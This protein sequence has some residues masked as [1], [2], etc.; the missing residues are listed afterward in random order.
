MLQARAD[1]VRHSRFIADSSAPGPP[2]ALDT[3]S[4]LTMR[5]TLAASALIALMTVAACSSAPPSGDYVMATGYADIRAGS[6]FAAKRAGA[7]KRA[8]LQAR[9][10][11]LNNILERQYPSGFNIENA[12]IEDPF[13]RAKVFD[14]IRM[15]K[16]VDQVDS[17]GKV[18]SVTLRLAASEV[19]TIIN[20]Y[21][22]GS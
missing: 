3:E 9:L 7:I 21:P 19:D 5:S 8:E 15:A 20:D 17:D 13:I 14:T 16:I 18:V 4:E 6:D 2:R 11:L 10:Q 1:S 12:V 22:Y